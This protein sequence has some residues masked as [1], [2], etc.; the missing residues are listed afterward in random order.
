M[1]IS[2]AIAVGGLVGGA[3]SAIAA[4]QNKPDIPNNPGTP[5]TKPQ[6]EIELSAQEKQNRAR[7]NALAAYGRT[8][9]LLTGPQGVND[10]Q[11]L[12][13]TGMQS[14]QQNFQTMGKSL[15]GQ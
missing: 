14:G 6:S 11:Q 9:T 13:G 12:G 10:P 8:D 7:K 3:V 1:G 4:K 5:D 2:A 15:L